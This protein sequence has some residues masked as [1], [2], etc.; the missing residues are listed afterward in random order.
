MSKSLKVK[1]DA[2]IHV[3]AKAKHAERN[4]DSHVDDVH[5]AQKI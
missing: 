3:E 5:L 1:L 4:T 2:M